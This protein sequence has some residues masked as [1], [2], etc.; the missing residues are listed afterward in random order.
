MKKPCITSQPSSSRRSQSGRCWT[1]SASDVILRLRASARLASTTE[2]FADLREDTARR[3]DAL[4]EDTA[5]RFD[6]VDARFDGVDARLDVIDR[7]ADAAALAALDQ[8]SL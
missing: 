1:P 7:M 6:A 2:R 3:F 4:R 8:R 5:K